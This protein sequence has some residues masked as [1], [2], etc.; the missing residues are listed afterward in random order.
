MRPWYQ[1]IEPIVYN[2]VMY[3]ANVDDVVDAV[4]ATTGDLL[5]RYRRELPDNVNIVTGTRGPGIGVGRS[6][7]TRSFWPP[8]TPF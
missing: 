4:D 5:W 1:E 7:P 8:T 2:G 6:S 3:L